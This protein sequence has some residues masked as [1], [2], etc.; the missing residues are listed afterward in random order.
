MNPPDRALPTHAGFWGYRSVGG[1]KTIREVIADSAGNL[2]SGGVRV[3]KIGGTWGNEWVESLRPS[4]APESGSR[5]NSDT[6]TKD[7]FKGEFALLAQALW[8]ANKATRR[9]YPSEYPAP[10]ISLDYLDNM[11]TALASLIASP[12]DSVE[13]ET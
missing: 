1:Y 9:S 11:A 7:G 12:P 2:F 6:E 5:W 4:F 10:R 8:D 13:V 3:D